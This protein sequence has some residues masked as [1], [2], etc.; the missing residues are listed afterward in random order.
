MVG[1][2][3][4]NDMYKKDD[5]KEIVNLFSISRAKIKHFIVVFFFLIEQTDSYQEV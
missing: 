3:V 4:A 5:R 2:V 1:L